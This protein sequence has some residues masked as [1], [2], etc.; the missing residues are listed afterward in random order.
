MEDGNIQDICRVGEF[1]LI[2]EIIEMRN[3]VASI[4]VYEETSMIGPG[5]PVVLTGEPLSVE[6]GPGIMAQMF[7]GIQRPL[8]SFVDQSES[9]Y[10]GRGVEV[11]PLDR[12]TEWTFTKKVDVGSAVCSGDIIGVVPENQY[13]EQEQQSVME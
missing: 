11:D 1:G 13:I 10:L 12:E 2:G 5:E 4:Q 8:Q 7:D 9:H 3:D 6:L